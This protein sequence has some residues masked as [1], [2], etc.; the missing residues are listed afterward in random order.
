MFAPHIDWSLEGY[1]LR[2]KS[3]SLVNTQ[4][5]AIIWESTVRN[6]TKNLGFQNFGWQNTAST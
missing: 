4:Q 2:N 6:G 5:A 1:W 3:V